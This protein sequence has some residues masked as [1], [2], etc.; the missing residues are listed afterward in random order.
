MFTVTCLVNDETQ[1]GSGLKAGHG[2]S[3][4]IQTDEKRLLFDTGPD[5]RVLLYN[6]TKLGLD[7]RAVADV[8]LSHSHPDHTGGLRTVLSLARGCRLFAHPAIFQARFARRRWW[9][10]PKYIGLPL[11]QREIEGY[12]QLKL[13]SQPIEVASQ[14]WTTGE[15]APRPEAE[16][17]SGRHLIHTPHGWAPDP[18]ADDMALVLETPQGLVVV[19]GCGHAG[20]LNTLA[21]VRQTFDSQIK[22]VLG[23]AHLLDLDEEEMDHIIAILKEEYRSL[24]LYL[25]HCTGDGALSL[26]RQASLEQTIP[27]PAGTSMEF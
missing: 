7:L 19:L 27:C 4:L 17:R 2:L 12:A 13:S 16:G 6:A 11:S 25:N 5:G 22:A 8:V 1:P 9:W 18:Y 24:R 20:L 15:V 23:G 14:V 21:H 10:R 3:F 26:L